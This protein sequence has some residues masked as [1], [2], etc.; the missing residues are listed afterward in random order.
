MMATQLAP[1]RDFRGP[2]CT[3]ACEVVKAIVPGRFGRT[4]LLLHDP[5]AHEAYGLA[6]A[7]PSLV[8]RTGGLEVDLGMRRVYAF[9]RHVPLIGREWAILETLARHPGRWFR[10]LEIVE[11]TWGTAWLAQRDPGHLARVNISR[12]R[13]R[14]A[15]IGW[16]LESDLRLGYRLKVVEPVVS[17]R[18]PE[19]PSSASRWAPKL[20]LDACIECG[21]AERAHHAR[22]RCTTCNSH[23]RRSRP[24]S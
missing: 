16:L 19:T 3:D 4:E 20:G 18:Q 8:V 6:L 24:A 9:G 21:S 14:L 10:T 5:D 22:G 12:M 13:S 15:P 23:E 17:E 1:E 7:C 2:G 11:A